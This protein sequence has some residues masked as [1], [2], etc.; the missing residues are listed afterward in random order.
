MWS[1]PRHFESREHFTRRGIRQHD[2]RTEKCYS[3]CLVN[4]QPTAPRIGMTTDSIWS[5]SQNADHSSIRAVRLV[6]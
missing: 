4:I 3:R 6:N 1:F 5:L 2:R